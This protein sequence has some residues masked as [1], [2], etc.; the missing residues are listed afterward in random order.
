MKSF[1]KNSMILIFILTSPVLFAQTVHTLTLE[2]AQ[3]Y[4]KTHNYDLKKALLDVDIAGK[5]VK[6]NLAIGFPQVEGEVT[7][8]NYIDIPTTLLPDFITP[9]IYNVNENKFGLT[10]TEP[11]GPVEFFPAQFGTEYSLSASITVTQLLFSGQYLVGLEGAR[12]YRQLSEQIYLKTN[13]S[14]NTLVAQAYYGVL[15]TLENKAVLDSNMLSLKQTLYETGEYYKMGFIE[16][17]DVDQLQLLVS[18]LEASLKTVENNISLSYSYLKFYLGIPATDSLVLVTR[19]QDVI[20]EMNMELLLQPSFNYRDHIDYRLLEYQK[21]LQTS[22]IKLAK[23][24]YMP[25][26]AGFFSAQTTAQRSAWN[27][28]KANQDWYPVT[29][30]GVELKVP[31]FS[32]GNRLY[33]LQ[34]AKLGLKKL[35]EDDSRLKMGLTLEHQQARQEFINAWLVYQ[36]KLKSLEYSGKIY[37]RTNEKYKEGISGSLDL[38]NTYNQYLQAQGEYIMALL[39][40]LNHKLTLEELLIKS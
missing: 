7:N 24:E 8:S 3:E 21:K 37:Q 17:T 25:T 13:I 18:D 14:V 31:I 1:L 34:Q 36:N 22:Q 19:L 20:L 4:A 5:R 23:A 16:E 39:S 12:I 11:L 32:S 35:E 6:E 26:L 40:L 28:Y 27:F 15:A 38:M 30:W 2:D 10:P 9:A 29:L 33:K